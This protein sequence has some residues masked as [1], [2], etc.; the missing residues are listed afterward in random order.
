M[1][2]DRLVRE[3]DVARHD[4]FQEIGGICRG[5]HEARQVVALRAASQVKDPLE[6]PRNHLE[7]A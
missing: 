3:L 2:G 6:M 4:V 1:H 7:M 5:T